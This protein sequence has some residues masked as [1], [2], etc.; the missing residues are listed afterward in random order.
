[1]MYSASH[2]CFHHVAIASPCFSNIFTMS[3]NAFNSKP[4]SAPNHVYPK[5]ILSHESLSTPNHFHP[6]KA[7]TLVKLSIV[8]KISLVNRLS[9]LLDLVDRDTIQVPPPPGKPPR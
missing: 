4:L 3:I 6:Q 5:I 9:P 2:I 1:M 8:P 7:F